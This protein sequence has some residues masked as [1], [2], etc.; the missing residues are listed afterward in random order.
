MFPQAS[1]MDV[2]YLPVTVENREQQSLCL[3]SRV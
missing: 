3:A 1:A 2:S